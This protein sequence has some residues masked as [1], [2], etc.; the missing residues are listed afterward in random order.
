MRSKASTVAR[1]GAAR[2]QGRFGRSFEAKPQGSRSARESNREG[3]VAD[4]AFRA[5]D[6]NNDGKLSGDEIAPE[7][8]ARLGSSQTVP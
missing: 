8:A 1:S 4:R 3:E 5:R 7:L 2:R 6:R